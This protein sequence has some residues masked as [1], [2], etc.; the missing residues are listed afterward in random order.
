MA[1]QIGIVP[2]TAFQQNCALFFDGETKRGAVFDPGGDVDEIVAA[3]EKAGMVPE[4]IYLTHGHLDH[5]GGAAELR[6]RLEVP[7]V[8]PHEADRMLLENIGKTASGYGLDGMRDVAPDRWLADGE[9]ETIAGIEFSVSHAPG[10]APGHVV[11]HSAALGFAHVGDVLFQ[12]SVGRTDLPGG[13]HETLLRSIKRVCLSWPDETRFLCG[14]GP[15]STIGAE[16]ASN[17]FLQGL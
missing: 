5:A 14:H 4:A 2:V 15:S 6:E 11:F 9:I 1:L 12:G 17:P 10:H 16:R 3:I 7:V 13:D 8:G